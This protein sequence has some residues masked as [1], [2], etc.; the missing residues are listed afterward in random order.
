MSRRAEWQRVCAAL[1]ETPRGRERA[2][3]ERAL[4]QLAVEDGRRALRSMS[5][6]LTEEQLDDLVHDFL[7]TRLQH[8]IETDNNPRGL[9]VVSLVRAAQRTLGRRG[10]E[11]PHERTTFGDVDLDRAPLDPESSVMLRLD[12]VALLSAVSARHPVR[13]ANS[14]QPS[15]TSSSRIRSARTRTGTGR[16]SCID[17]FG[18]GRQAERPDVT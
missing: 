9:F 6:K 17:V 18:A 16:P 1:R 13:S 8:V 3:Y 14:P 7:A 2:R 11:V 15:K 4:Y 5:R 12:G 10:R